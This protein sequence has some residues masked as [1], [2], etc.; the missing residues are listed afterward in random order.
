MEDEAVAAGRVLG[1]MEAAANGLNLVILDACRNN[2]YSRRF[3]GSSLEGLAAPTQ[4]AR[5]SLIAYATSPNSVAEDG[6]GRNGLYTKHLLRFMRE[7]GLG[8][9]E[10]FKQV[11]IAVR[12]ES[13]G[14][15]T[16]W[17]SSSLEGDFSFTVAASGAVPEPVASDAEA[18][19]LAA[20]RQR[21]AA[22]RRRL[23][24]ER[25]LL[26]EQRRLAEERRQLEEQ[27]R[28]AAAEAERRRRELQPGRRFRDCPECPEMV[29][30]AAGSFMM[31]SPA[32]EEGRWGS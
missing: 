9:E 21:V 11:R 30:V 14:R 32:S 8:V 31:G 1:A 5:G 29:V 27:Q 19:R 4:T 16:P 26:A 20:E 6:T 25:E 24:E 15:Q 28:E 3:R 2:P 10:M 23:A 17:E 7:P 13:G 22:E 18:Q 12:R